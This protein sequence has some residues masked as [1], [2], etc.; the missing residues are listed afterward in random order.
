MARLARHEAGNESGT[1]KKMLALSPRTV[2]TMRQSVPLY[3]SSS[4]KRE[5]SRRRTITIAL[6]FVRANIARG[7][8]HAGP[9]ESSST[10]RAESS[11]S[12]RATEWRGDVLLRGSRT[13]RL[14]TSVDTK[15]NCG[16]LSE[17]VAISG[18]NHSGEGFGRN[19]MHYHESL[20]LPTPSPATS[21]TT[22]TTVMGQMSE[23]RSARSRCSG[24]GKAVGMSPSAPSSGV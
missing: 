23:R 9:W 21:A 4:R 2:T 13:H 1:K 16:D 12:I 15:A 3:F 6:S 10:K 19:R 5:H 11:P 14:A 22:S 17:R 24:N 20:D 18:V 8:R 7:F